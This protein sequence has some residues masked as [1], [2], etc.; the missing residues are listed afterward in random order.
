M[1]A[2]K[3]TRI[4]KKAIKRLSFKPVYILIGLSLFIIGG[5]VVAYSR[6]A[7]DASLSNA[8]VPVIHLE[9]GSGAQTI[10][11]QNKEPAQTG[12]GWVKSW[13]FWD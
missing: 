4:S 13:V 1:S 9:I 11:K 8:S 3:R 2:R 6:A 5:F 10:E 7:T 12:F